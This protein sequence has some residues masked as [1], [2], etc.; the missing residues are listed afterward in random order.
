MF[1]K[2]VFKKWFLVVLVIISCIFMGCNGIKESFTL[3]WVEYN[4]T[5]QLQVYYSYDG[6]TWNAAKLPANLTSKV[7]F[8]P[9]AT[10]DPTGIMHLVCW[11]EPNGNLMGIFGLTETEYSI[12]KP[13]TVISAQ[14]FSMESGAAMA[15]TSTERWYFAYRSGS[16]AA[17]SYWERKSIPNTNNFTDNWFNETPSQYVINA[18]VPD[19]PSISIKGTRAIMTWYRN[20]EGIGELQIAIG[21]VLENGRISWINGYK[22]TK[23]EPN[24]GELGKS[25]GL[26]NNGKEFFLCVLRKDLPSSS[27]PTNTFYFYKSVD[28]M[29]WNFHTKVGINTPNCNISPTPN[30]PIGIAANSKGVLIVTQ[31]TDFGFKKMWLF[32]NNTWSYNPSN[33]QKNYAY[34]KMHF[35]LIVTGCPAP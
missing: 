19:R 4:T 31:P 35:S 30:A 5:R 1:L 29:K 33:I 27:I 10:A 8:G 13:V 26:C 28:G 34:D 14:N 25:H 16:N 24:A 15:S 20:P 2:N 18:N 9:G 22:F 12:T 21:N 7:G 17:L 23:N 6:K 32:S 3:A 11:Q